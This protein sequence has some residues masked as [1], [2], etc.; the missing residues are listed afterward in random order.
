[1][2]SGSVPLKIDSTNIEWFYADLVPYVNYVPIKSDFS[3]LLSQV[4]WLKAND[5]KAKEISKN[6]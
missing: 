6:A 4:E 3:D 5:D 1:M 2:L